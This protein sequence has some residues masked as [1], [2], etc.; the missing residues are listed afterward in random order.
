MSLYID[1][2]KLDEVSQAVAQGWL[3][4]ITTN[5]TILAQGGAEPLATLSS[6]SK[7]DVQE[8]YY[9]VSSEE[10]AQMKKEAAQAREVLG[11]RLVVKI[12][13]TKA[14]FQF[15]ARIAPEQKVCITAIYSPSQAIVAR[16]TG[17][18]YIAVY[19]NR[20]TRLIGDGFKVTA[21]IAAVLA[22]G[23]TEILAASLKSPQ[24][25][26]AAYNAGAPHL[27]LPFDVLMALTE[28][29]FSAQAVDQFNQQGVYL[30]GKG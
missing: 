10:P 17:A 19:V 14:G 13:P 3:Y 15:A 20:A 12:P 6:L 24:E 4:G 2:A 9:Q 23:P 21:E 16:Q 5:P 25:A 30:P 11:D 8:I 28:N 18:R 29:P 1:S 27:T 26:V 22:G 7:F